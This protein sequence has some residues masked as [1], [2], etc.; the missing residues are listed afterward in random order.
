VPTRRR[1]RA[2]RAG[3]MVSSSV[4]HDTVAFIVARNAALVQG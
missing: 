2:E 4:E 1:S 3:G